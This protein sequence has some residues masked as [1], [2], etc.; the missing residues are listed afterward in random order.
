M[1]GIFRFILTLC[2]FPLL[3]TTYGRNR[4][5]SSS[6][7]SAQ[8]CNV[9][10]YM[11]PNL[12]PSKNSLEKYE[13]RMSF[14]NQ[15]WKKNYREE[16]GVFGSPD[17]T[18]EQ[19]ISYRD[20][21][22]DAWKLCPPFYNACPTHVVPWQITHVRNFDSRKNLYEKVILAVRN[23]SLIHACTGGSLNVSDYLVTTNSLPF[24]YPAWDPNANTPQPS[25]LTTTTA[26]KKLRVL[27][28]GVTVYC[29]FWEYF[30]NPTLVDFATVEFED[31]LKYYGSS[32][33]HLVADF[34]T[35]A[36]Y[37]DMH[38]VDVFLVLFSKYGLG[39]SKGNSMRAL[40]VIDHVLSPT[41]VFA[42]SW[43]QGYHKRDYKTAVFP[44]IEQFNS[45]QNCFVA[46]EWM[47][48]DKSFYSGDN[49]HNQRMKFF[50]K[51]NQTLNHA[52]DF[53]SG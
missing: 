21:L 11:E 46:V 28:V 26:V 18:P 51:R 52:C 17:G 6:G 16:E 48:L 13:E 41:G 15:S 35:L 4:F 49:E 34:Y 33:R 9:Q 43:N 29:M 47:G 3:L 7:V 36:K 12:P 22:R 10:T 8:A 1:F 53:T 32:Q 20:A 38:S 14:V 30:F 50:K 2:L 24:S 44:I 39:K 37:I 23:A 25:S 42:V 45:F 40:Q 31:Y 27:S 19:K 5:T